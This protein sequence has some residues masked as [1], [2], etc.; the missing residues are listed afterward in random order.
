MARMK[1]E[2]GFYAHSDARDTREANVDRLFTEWCCKEEDQRSEEFWRQYS[3][4]QAGE[5]TGMFL[6]LR[7]I[8]P[9]IVSLEEGWE[10]NISWYHAEWPWNFERNTKRAVFCSA[11]EAPLGLMVVEGLSI[12]R[13]YFVENHRYQ[14]IPM[15]WLE[16]DTMKFTSRLTSAYRKRHFGNIEVVV[17]HTSLNTLESM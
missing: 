2:S 8:Y 1:N 9:C 11:P 4:I 17:E 10:P 7:S 6:N 15:C 14:Y 5:R 13:M 3:Q 16:L 12:D